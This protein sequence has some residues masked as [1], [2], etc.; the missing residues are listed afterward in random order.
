VAGVI[1]MVEALRHGTL[2]R[3]LHIDA[4]SSKVE[5]GEGA[6]EL[7]TEA[8]P[9]PQQADR[10]RRAGISSFGVSGTNAHVVLEQAPTAPDVLTEPRASA[11]LPVT[12]LPLSAAGAE[13][14][15][16]Q[17]RRLA[18]HLVAHAEI[19]PAD[20]AYSAAT[21]RATLANRAVVL[22]DDREPLIARL[23]ALAEGRRDADVTVG[24]AGSGR[25]PVFV[26]P[27]QGSQWAGM[28][29]ELLEMAPVFRAK[30]EE[31][32]RA[33]APHLDWSVLDVLR[34]AP[35]A[36]PIDRADVVQPALFTMMISLAA[37]WEAHGVRPAV[38][39]GHSQG[40]VAAAYVAGILSLDDAARVIAERSRLWGRLAGNGGM[41]AVMAPADRVRELVEPW[42][43]RISVAA[44]NGPAS[45]TVAGDTA[46][47]EEFSERL[48]ADRVLRWPLAGVDFAGHSPQ[49][50]QFRT[51]LLA[52]L[53]GVRPTAARLPFFST[54]TAGA[55]APEGLD[56]AY[57]Y[58]NM[59][60]P[61]E[62]E[63]TLRALLR[64][65]HR[66]FIEMGPH[67]LL[68]AAINE[69]AE[70]EGVHAT[71]LST[72]Y[73]DSGGLDRFRASA[74]AAFAHGVR[75]DWAPFFEGTGAR[76]VSLPTYAFRRDR[77]WLPT[78]TSRRAADAAAIA[79]ATASDAWRYRVTWT[80]LET[81]DSGAPSG[82]WLL[83]E[84]TDAAPGE[85]DAAASA[86][87]TAGAVVERWTLDPTVVTRAGLTERLAG[88][89][90]E[91]QGLAG[92]LVLPGQAAD[93]APADAS[94]LDE[95]TA[96]VLLVTQ[97]VTDG[98]P[99]ARIWV[100][101]RGAVAVE[102]DDVPCVRGARVW[103]LGLVAALEAPM[104]WGGLVDLPVKPG[105][106]D[107]RRLAAAL[108]TSSG[109]DQVAIRGTG[110]YGRRLLPAA[111]AAV[112]GSWRP[113]G[114]V[115]VTGGT[116]GLGGHVA[117]WLAREGAEHVVLA[118]RRGAEAPGAGELE[119]ELLGLGTKVTVV[120]CDI[121]DRTSVMQLL[122]AIKGLGTPLRGV[123]HAAGVA[124]VTPLAEVEL[125]EA[126]DV[127]A[128]KAVGAELLDEF[129]ADAELDT[130][131]L[132]SS[133]AAVWGS[134]GQSVY[135]AA[136]AHLNA[137]AE[138]RRAQGRPATSVAWGLWGGSGMGAGDGVTDFYA[139][140]GLAPMRPDLGIEALHGALNQDDTCVTVADID[141][142]HFVT[143]FT[144]FRP[145]PL[146][147]DIP[148]VRELRAA[149]P[150]LDASDELRGR[151]DAALTPRER[152]K[153]LVDLVRTVAAEI[154]GHDGIGRIGH[155]VAFKDLGFDSLAAVRLRGRLAESTGLTLPATV[156]FD[157]PTVDQLGA[158]LLAELTDGSNQGGAVVPAC[159]G[160]N[161]TP[162]HTPEATAHDV[163]ID[164]L[165]ADDLI[166]LATA[167]KDNG[168]DALS[169]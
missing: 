34:G 71:A 35:D 129:T 46:A 9:W 38:V 50:E 139:E 106:V 39:V 69:V 16:E 84:T 119:Q 105:E 29:A 1:K 37:L 107:W 161:E 10:P 160:G 24:E 138:R 114:C 148:Q 89:T 77:F 43:Q 100:A 66:S 121:S 91:P 83:V 141:W 17:A 49:V 85:A 54:V 157:H 132:F 13:P 12:V 113:R 117:R 128:G 93:T 74:G 108:S 26:F 20:A 56:A 7:L 134:G 146:I 67:P 136:N 147:S 28:G 47:L 45:V 36:P 19:T 110:T 95:S 44:V 118:G 32:A 15:R 81:V 73:R 6:V 120:A 31:C 27:G 70:D 133:G 144:A 52:T 8:R 145:S 90:A 58:R 116:G 154:L 22:A 135:A 102:S 130:F 30:A 63:S 127:L 59:R 164:E 3:S 155:D 111:P 53:A 151:I 2:P 125:D 123:F 122:D 101:T 11:A 96:A 33:L 150:T 142:E 48:S 79:T 168:D 76:R 103:G 57:W 165:D 75:V 163:E 62:F 14:L 158:A 169:G 156:I 65:G 78:A 23:T 98:A 4:P 94:P 153:V 80:A 42:A 152:T 143:G 88:L 104:Q 55:H 86:L 109:E 115:L 51:E 140:R 41:L 131:V 162:A 21:G 124:Q 112:R 126:A 159:A 64:Q 149:A 25:P 60:E 40:E 72:L 137:L 167:G 99:K 18:E 68:G 97:A 166:R 87:G 5:W 92:V 61:V 82:R